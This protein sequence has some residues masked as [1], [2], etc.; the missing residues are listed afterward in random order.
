MFSPAELLVA[1]HGLDPGRDGIPP[2]SLMTAV[3]TALHTPDVFP[4]TAVAQVGEDIWTPA[5]SYTLD[6]YIAVMVLASW[7]LLLIAHH[8]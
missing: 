5:H 7:W 4:Q 2:R 8:L 1:L 6:T 3:D